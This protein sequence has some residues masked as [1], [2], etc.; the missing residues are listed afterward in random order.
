MEIQERE[1][2]LRLALLNTLLTTPHRDLASIYPVHQEIIGRDPLFYVQLAAWYAE[3]GE[4]RDHK[5]MFVVNLVL[6]DFPG[7]REVGL[8]LLREMPPYQV[9]RVLDFTKGR[10]V[11]RCVGSTRTV[12]VL[13][14]RT[15]TFLDLLPRA[16]R[17]RVR[18][19]SPAEV[20]RIENVRT[21]TEQRGLFRNVPR[22]MKTE[23]TRYLR[24]READP[25]W[26]DSTVLQARKSVK[27]LYASLH[28]EP[29]PRAQAILFDDNPPPDSRLYMLKQ[30]AQAKSPAEQARAIVENKIPYRVAASVIKEM[31]P[32]VLV[33]LINSMSPQEVINNMASLKR[34]G[35][36]DNPDLKAL[37]DG[38][39]EQAKT[40]KR[41]SAYKAKQAV[42]AAGVSGETA[43][44]LDAVT[45]TRVKARGTIVLPTALLIDK[46]GSMVQA[47][48]I[49]KRIAALIAGICEAP[50]YVYA[51]DTIPYPIR[52]DRQKLIGRLRGLLSGGEIG[53]AEGDIPQT[54][55]EWEAAMKGINAGGQTSC[56]VAVQHMARRREVVEQIVMVTDEE[57]NTS[58]GFADAW[59]LYQ[60]EVKTAPN[61]VFVKTQGAT[62]RLERACRAANIPFDAYQF[63]GDYYAL[64]NLVPMLTRASK[65]ELLMDIMAYPLPQRK[66]A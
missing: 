9:N 45:E 60:N 37:I 46:S 6:S 19:D 48:E 56:G 39:L 51:F 10:T 2:D 15:N 54:L 8:A 16:I 36:L 44:K 47:I 22:A 29:S 58:P 28:I 62:D 25:V 27:S 17:Q 26:F 59:K 24:E 23:V 20:R 7:H 1:R 52:M 32:T 63:T 33:A 5:E 57:E 11:R 42:R 31:T 12:P 38:K 50:L 4:V 34:H 66:P 18:P 40:D 41:V 30:I 53:S 43:E 64:P 35:A 55:A 14:E 21:I 3:E 13:P 65:L 49:G 61:V